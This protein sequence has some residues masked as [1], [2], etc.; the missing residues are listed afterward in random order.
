MMNRIKLLCASGL[1]FL[2]VSGC[3][4]SHKWEQQENDQIDAY[5]QS[6]GDTVY[7]KRPSG[8]YYIELQAGTGQMPED[9]DIISF[10][11][12]GMFLNRGVF[13][14]NLKNA[15][16]SRTSVGTHSMMPG[17]DEG[18][19]YMKTG[20]KSRFL[21]PSNL[22]YGTYG[23]PPYISG[24]TPL[25]WEFQLLTVIPGLEVPQIQYYIESL[26]DTVHS[27]KPSG[28][29]YVESLAGT[30]RTPVLTDTV[31]IKYKGMFLD[32]VVFDSNIS[33]T[34]TLKFVLGK[35]EV[36]SGLEEGVKYMKE[37]GKAKLVIP[38][39]LAYGTS[40]SGTTIA[41]NTPLLFEI[42]IVSVKAGTVK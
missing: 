32:R 35:N 29:Y 18:V 23:A 37:G 10:R 27:L 40:G 20:G 15:V 21:T 38:S 25:L 28:L 31:R 8:L 34:T 17:L 13:D 6:L 41:G 24:Y 7:S 11:Y 19:R 5:V 22:A 2:F 9:G 12:A 3:N 26:G 4:M 14:S 42:E 36:I 16:A 33:S 39:G 30:G 1:I